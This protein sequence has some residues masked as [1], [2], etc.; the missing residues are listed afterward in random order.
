MPCGA[1]PAARPQPALR[2]P[3]TSSRS[4][5]RYYQFKSTLDIDHYP[6]GGRDQD[7]AI[8]VRELNLSGISRSTVVEQ[9]PRLHPRV[10]RGGGADRPRWTRRPAPRSSS[11]AACPPR[12][13]S[14]STYPQIYFGQHSPS[15]SIVGQPPGSTKRRRV[16]PP[17]HQRRVGRQFTRRT[18]AAAACR[19]A[20]AST[21]L[22]Y[23]V[24]LARPE[25][26]LLP[27][28]QLRLAVAHGARSAPP[29]RAG[30]AVADSRRRR[31]PRPGRRPSA[32]GR[33]RLHVDRELPR[34]RA[35]QPA[36][37]DVELADERDGHRQ[38]AEH[39]RQLPA[40]LGEGRR[41]RLQRPGHAVLLESAGPARP[42]AAD[43]GERLPRPRAARVEH[44]AGA[45]EAPCATRRTSSTCSASCS[46]STTWPTPATSTTAPTSGRSPPTR[47]SRPRIPSTAVG[48]AAPRP[49][50]RRRT[51]RSPPPATARRSGP[52]PRRW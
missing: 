2:R 49:R 50:S 39:P 19:S 48:P 14:R 22:L 40:Q 7:V 10:R 36:P 6:L 28:H 13:R 31:L 5:R 27:R 44:P 34:V 3:S 35:G 46:P 8:A 45:A 37:G 21:R 41:R 30:R 26:L 16:R 24:K 9:P 32:V 1:D 29:G 25:H 47:P 42:G 12:T 23:A 51:C 20:L 4:S 18:T 11:T 43:L 52:C 38:P 33:R 15:Y 17:E